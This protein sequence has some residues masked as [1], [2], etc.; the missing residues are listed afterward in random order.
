MRGKAVL[1]KK[2][3]QDFQIWHRKSGNKVF[4]RWAS[5]LSHRLTLVLRILLNN[6]EIHLHND[7]AWMKVQVFH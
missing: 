4:L 7:R 6:S 1:K 3:P 5:F 2:N